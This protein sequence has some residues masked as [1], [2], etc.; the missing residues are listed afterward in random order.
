MAQTGDIDAIGI[1]YLRTTLSRFPD[2]IDMALRQIKTRASRNAASREPCIII[3]R[4]DE[5]VAKKRGWLSKL[6]SQ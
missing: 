5:L 6:R 4:V 2:S 1:D 3:A